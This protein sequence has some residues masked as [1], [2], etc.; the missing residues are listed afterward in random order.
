[1]PSR[2]CEV[3]QAATAS[4]TQAST[5][6]TGSHTNKP[7]Q[8]CSSATAANSPTSAASAHGTTKPNFISPS[9]RL[10]RCGR[11][12]GCTPRTRRDGQLQSGPWIS[13]C[14]MRTT[15]VASRC[16]HGSTRTRTRR[17]R[18]LAEAGYVAPAMAR[19]V[20]TRRRPDPPTDRRRR[21]V[22]SEGPPPGEPD[23]HRLGRS[24]LDVR[25]HRRAE[26]AVPS[27]DAVRRG[28]L[29]PVVQRARQRQRPG[30]PRHPCSSRRRRVRGQ[31]SED[32]DEWRSAR[33]VRDPSRPNRSRRAE[34]Q[35]H[36]VLHL[37]D[38]GSGDRDPSD[39]GDDRWPHLQRGVLH[40]CSHPGRQP[41]RRAQRRLAAR[42]GHARQRTHFA[43]DRRS[44]VG[45]RADGARA[46][47]RRPRIVDR[48]PIPPCASVS[49]TSTSSTP[50]S[51]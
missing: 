27:A 12:T 39:H 8:P 36:L 33:G 22:E 11:A 17:P 31:R 47:R 9:S 44:P 29:V 46:D 28:V 20:G 34:A 50:C 15:R 35:G 3:R 6:H 43:V 18:Q 51:T 13:S 25:G 32:L 26:A 48:S 2:S 7:S 40:R 1:M 10:P 41:R 19:A 4:E 21:V 38:E 5:P 30:Q 14:P 45:Q 24:D 23:R 42:Q 49:P 16:A 37:P